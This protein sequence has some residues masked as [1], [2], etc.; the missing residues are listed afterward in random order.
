MRPFF[1]ACSTLSSRGWESELN[2]LASCHSPG[3]QVLRLRGYPEEE[4]SP[5]GILPKI[6]A[7]GRENEC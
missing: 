7:E 1:H 3:R 4:M 6:T 5:E 2:R